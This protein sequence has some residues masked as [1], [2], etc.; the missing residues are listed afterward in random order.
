MNYRTLTIAISFIVLA[1]WSAAELPADI[2][3]TRPTVDGKVTEILVNTFLID[4]SK[5]DGSDQSFTADF[6]VLLRWH[7]PRLEGVFKATD[8]VPLD[9]IWNPRLQIL[10]RRDLSTTFEDQPEVTPNGAVIFRQRYFGTFPHPWTSTISPS[11]ASN[12]TSNWWSPATAP[13]RL[14]WSRIRTDRSMRSGTP[15]FPSPTGTSATSRRT[16]SRSA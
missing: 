1:G 16:P 8:R 13:T 2:S 12:F 3:G 5:V 4:I 14:R 9:E 10:N 7:D 15:R 6:F 11:T